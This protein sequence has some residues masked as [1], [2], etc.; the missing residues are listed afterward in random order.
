MMAALVLPPLAEAVGWK[1]SLVVA[2]AVCVVGGAICYAWYVDCPFRL[3]Q[4][5]ACS[6][7]LAFPSALPPAERPRGSLVSWREV[8][9]LL[10]RNMLLL[11]IPATFYVAAQFII[12]T[13]LQLF[14]RETLG[15]HPT[16]AANALALT[17]FFG[18]VSRI[19]WG[20]VSDRFFGGSRKKVI[21][22]LGC[23][24]TLGAL[25]MAAVR[26]GVHPGVPLTL[27]A[28]LGSTT[29]GWNGLLVTLLSELAG[30]DKAGTAVG[31]GLTFT[32][33]GIISGP[34]LFGLV[35]D[36]TGSYRAGWLLVA[37]ALAVGTVC[38]RYVE[39]PPKTAASG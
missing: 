15:F 6:P 28:V 16:R 18:I 17:Q 22:L 26:R 12:V 24:M 4:E 20:H 5:P 3:T 21:F 19:G 23:G 34:P 37:L 31:I 10:D 2:G 30:K 13:Y 32:Q 38:V 14:L 8:S 33:I 35:A 39:E 7:G 9:A 27:A 1:T 11:G 29:I 25:G 36:V